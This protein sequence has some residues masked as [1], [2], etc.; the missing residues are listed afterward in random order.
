MRQAVRVL[1]TC[2]LHCLPAGEQQLLLLL[3]AA[4]RMR[5]A[6]RSA[7]Q[8]DSAV[9]QALHTCLTCCLH[10]PL[11]GEQLLMLAQVTLLLLTAAGQMRA[12]GR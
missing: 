2:C 12:A 4:G 5:A 11:A 9:Q 3:A 1:P 7:V 8:L 10:R 6:A